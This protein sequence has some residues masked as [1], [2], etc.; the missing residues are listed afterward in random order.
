MRPVSAFDELHSIAPQLVWAGI[1]ARSVHGER[2]TMAVVELDAGAVVAEHRHDH[3]QI[4]L[5]VRG[6]IDF[7]IG[8]ERRELRPGA[9]YVI[10]SNI[11]HD[12]VAGAEGAVVIDVFAP[13]REEWKHQEELETRA[14]RW[15]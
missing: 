9:A 15:P 13:V 2:L 5:V 3:E 7:R 12:A 1:A 6:T 11:P 14:P 10:P 4:G 8:G